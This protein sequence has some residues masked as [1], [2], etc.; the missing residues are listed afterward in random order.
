MDHA[1]FYVKPKSSPE[2]EEF[3]ARLGEKNA[4]PLWNVL[5]AIVPPEPQPAA[6]PAIWKYEDIRPLLM[7]AGRL[8]TAKEAERRVLMLENPGLQGASRIT[9]SLYAGL[10]LILPGEVAPSHR[11]RPRPCVWSSKAKV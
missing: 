10:Q 8:I 5:G 6:I 3:N 1:A 2:R 11:H 7:E 9:Q 4:A